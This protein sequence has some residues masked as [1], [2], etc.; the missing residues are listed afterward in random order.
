MC[1]NVEDAKII[2]SA[3]NLDPLYKDQGNILNSQRRLMSHD[4]LNDKHTHFET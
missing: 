4:T 1:L 2:E 3:L